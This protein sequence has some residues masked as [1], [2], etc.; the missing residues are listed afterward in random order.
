MS[1]PPERNRP[2]K[3]SRAREQL[4]HVNGGVS[5]G[6]TVT[7]GRCRSNPTETSRQEGGTGVIPARVALRVTSMNQQ[8]EV[9]RIMMGDAVDR[10]YVMVRNTYVA[11][12]T[13]TTYKGRQTPEREGELP[14]QIRLKLKIFLNTHF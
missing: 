10:S 1:V 7:P 9:R 4:S 5:E 14:L 12:D 11:N 6:R 8:E 13:A 3:R 2:K